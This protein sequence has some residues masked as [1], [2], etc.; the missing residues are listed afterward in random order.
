MARIRTIKPEFFRHFELY[1][2]EKESQ[3]PLRIAFAGLWTA[4]DREGR[5][6]WK[7]RELKLDAMPHDDID[8]SRVLDALTTRGFIVKYASQGALFGCIPSWNCHQSINNR[9]SE[10]VLPPPSEDD[11]SMRVLTREPRVDDASPTPLMQ[12]QGEGKGREGKTRVT[13]GVVFQKPN[14]VDDDVW[15]AWLAVRKSKKATAISEFVIKSISREAAEAGMSL[16][17]AITKCVEKNW[18]SFDADWVNK[19]GKQTKSVDD[20]FAGMK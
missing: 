6:K 2:A 12:D 19:P 20:Q 18:I 10:S 16:N 11:L 3:L 8:F 15:S 7:P 5:F 13:R 9:E 1:E 14:D 4:A 17:E